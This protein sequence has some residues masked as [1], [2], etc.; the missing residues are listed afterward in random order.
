M[1]CDSTRSLSP[2]SSTR[3]SQKMAS[4]SASGSTIGFFRAS[5][6][7]S[8]GR[9][10]S[11]PAETLSPP[12]PVAAR[13]N[14]PM[15]VNRINRE[16]RCRERW[17]FIAE[18]FRWSC[19]ESLKGFPGASLESSRAFYHG[20]F[21]RVERKLELFRRLRRFHRFRNHKFLFRVDADG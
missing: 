3:M 10:S 4:A 17:D 13:T 11:P 9:H 15:A 8:T 7:G 19:A 14:T 1:K 21:G 12:A 6:A 16:F 20:L 5:S 18:A 2:P